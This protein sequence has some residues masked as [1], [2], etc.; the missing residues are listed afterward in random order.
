MYMC[1]F[2][3]HLRL[4]YFISTPG[5]LFSVIA[6]TQVIASNIATVV[7][8]FFYPYTLNRGWG[9]GTVFF[10]M[11]AISVLPIPLVM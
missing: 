11:A 2:N 1:I 10:L 8:Y 6:M 5:A 7:F 9:V 3:Q 4:P